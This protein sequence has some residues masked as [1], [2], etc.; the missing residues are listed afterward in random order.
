MTQPFFTRLRDYYSKVGSVLRGEAATASIFPNTTDIGISRERVYAEFLKTH[1]PSSCNVYFGGFVFGI[2]G[3]ESHQIDLLVTGDASPQ[4]NFH[5]PDGQGKTFACIDG[6]LA[7]AS[8]KSTLNSAE[9]IDSL[10]NLASLPLKSNQA[11]KVMPL[12]TVPN[13]ADW[14][15]K[16]IY[17]SNGISLETLGST[18][19]EFYLSS[20]DIPVTSRPNLIHVAGKYNIVRTGQGGGVTRDGTQLVEYSFHGHPD[21][22]DV[23]AL[24]YAVQNIQ[25][26]AVAAKH[27]LYSYDAILENI[28]F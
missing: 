4:Y 18:L 14:P 20:P 22:T 13:Y 11:G 26:N 6:L 3:T 12:L 16:I 15:F 28:P 9:L 21:A 10:K 2:D 25:K 24:A 8:I 17:A 5:N 7:V 19:N 27:I 23:F 1:L